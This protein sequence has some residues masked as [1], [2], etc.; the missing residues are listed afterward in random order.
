MEFAKKFRLDKATKDVSPL[1]L[2][3]IAASKDPIGWYNYVG[4]LTCPLRVSTLLR[5]AGF[6]FKAASR[7]IT[8]A[9]HKSRARRYIAMLKH[10][11]SKDVELSIMWV[12]G[13]CLLPEVK[14]CMLYHL[15]EYFTPQDPNPIL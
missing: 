2:R 14:G 7:P 11:W 8:S 9:R 15:L 6:G 4:T 5:I 10:I 1:S 13:Q 12:S 3:K